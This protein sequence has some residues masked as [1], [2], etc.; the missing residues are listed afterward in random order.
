MFMNIEEKK[1]GEA[2]RRAI[3]RSPHSPADIARLFRVTPQA[4]NNWLK[5]GAS[6]KHGAELGTLLDIEPN[7]ISAAETTFYNIEEPKAIYGKIT[8][9]RLPLISEVQAGN[10]HEAIDRFQ[11]GDAEEWVVT[12]GNFSESSF[13]LTVK[14]DSMTSQ[15]PPSIPHGST[16]LVDPAIQPEHGKL[17]VAKLTDSNEVTFKRLSIDGPRKYLEPLNKEYERME[18]NGNCEIIGV[19]K[20]FITN[21]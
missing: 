9:K 5:R 3:E 14:G 19:V 12:T 11:P 7:K 2:L 21:L 1:K 17:V 4:V 6:A 10:W 13:A 8:I 16:I 20:Q 15:T 18:V